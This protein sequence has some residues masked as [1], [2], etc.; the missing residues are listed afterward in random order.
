MIFDEVK[1][2]STG[3]GRQTIVSFYLLPV[4]YSFL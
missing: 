2:N 1:L 3:I 4:I